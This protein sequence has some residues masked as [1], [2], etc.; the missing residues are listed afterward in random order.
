MNIE[1]LKKKNLDAVGIAN[2]QSRSFEAWQNSD[3]KNL[4]P[5]GPDAPVEQRPY[6]QRPG[7]S[8]D[9]QDL[10]Q[11]GLKGVGQGQEV[12]L[13]EVDK[14]YSSLGEEGKLRSSP[15]TIPWTSDDVKKMAISNKKDKDVT[16]STPTSSVQKQQPQQPQ[17]Q[18][19]PK[20]K[21][22]FGLF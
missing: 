4:F 15:F 1:D 6:I 5:V 8:P 14:K 18:Q 19:E 7:G 12:K 10:K 13:T 21:G 22:F 11:K 17:Q 20:K 16:K 3:Q 2:F 9:D